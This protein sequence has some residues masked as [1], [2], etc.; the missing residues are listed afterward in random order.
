[1]I[2]CITKSGCSRRPAQALAA[3]RRRR[4]RR[5]RR[6]VNGRL[7]SDARRSGD[8]GPE[9]V[10]RGHSRYPRFRLVTQGKYEYHNSKDD[11]RHLTGDPNSTDAP[12]DHKPHR[13]QQCTERSPSPPTITTTNERRNRYHQ[14]MDRRQKRGQQDSREP[15]SAALIRKGYRVDSVRANAHQSSAVSLS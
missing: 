12:Y 13:R 2:S 4:S 11:H 10:D 6:S 1:M 5:Q 7:R 9:R 3:P 15:A 8:P 14:P